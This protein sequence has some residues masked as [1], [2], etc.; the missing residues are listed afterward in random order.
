[1]VRSTVESTLQPA[2]EPLC[3]EASCAHRLASIEPPWVRLAF[4]P[5]IDWHGGGLRGDCVVGEYQYII[6]KYCTPSST[7][8]S[9]AVPTAWPSE[10]RLRAADVHSKDLPQS[11][12]ADVTAL[13]ANKTVI[14]MGDSVMEQFYNALQCMLQKEQLN[15][16]VDADFQAAMQRTLPLWLRGARK[17]PPK[18]PQMAR[19]GSD[20]R[21]RMRLLFERAVKFMA[22]DVDAALQ[23]ADVLVV[24]WG[25]HYHEMSEYRRD[26]EHAMALFERFVTAKPG[27]AVFIRETGAQHFRGTAPGSHGEWESRDVQRDSQCT[28]APIED[29]HVN[30]QNGVLRDVLAARPHPHPSVRLLPFYA[31]T[32]PRWRWHFGNCTNRPNGWGGS[33]CCDCTHYCYSPAMWQAHLHDLKAGLQAIGFRRVKSGVGSESTAG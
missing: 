28:C 22:E 18:L 26:L 13:L 1:M 9:A 7:T 16:P 5:R 25:L 3:A 12:L 24:N 15:V 8:M 20:W 17:M 29:Y 19:A 14:V 2:L 11:R 21:L 30:R 33:L 10:A 27:R 31:L 6:D 4:N 23:T 32:R